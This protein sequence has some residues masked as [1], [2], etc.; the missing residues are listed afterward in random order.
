M[1]HGLWQENDVASVVPPR[2]F[3][4]YRQICTRGFMRSLSPPW[5]DVVDANWLT[6]QLLHGRRT[7]GCR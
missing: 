4:G 2:D 6:K 5:V 3:A 7:Y 1:T